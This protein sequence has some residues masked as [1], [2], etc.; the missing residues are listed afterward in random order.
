[1]VDNKKTTKP[2]RI[3]HEIRAPQVR[4]LNAEGEQV[5]VISLA[6][7]LSEAQEMDLDLVEINPQSVPPV[8]K[9]M[10]Y[11]KHLYE[12]H[13]SL[14]QQKKKQKS[15]QIK[16]VKLRPVTD[17]ADYQLKIKN[18]IKFLEAGDK[19]KVTVSF[20]GREVMHQQLGRNL[21]DRVKLD[22]QEHA[23]LEMQNYGCEG[24]QINLLLAP[25]KKT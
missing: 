3:N 20:R 25:K 23:V 13:K 19:V 6:R 8:C 4:L 24:R 9:I 16:E 10:D 2:N 18:L 17:I 1:M 22:T 11:G 7:A 21:L 12:R 14:K 5:G 15:T